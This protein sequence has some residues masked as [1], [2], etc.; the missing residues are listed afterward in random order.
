[1]G[2]FIL[3]GDGPLLHDGREY[4]PGETVEMAPEAAARFRP[5]RLEEG[6]DP[7]G[8]N[9]HSDPEPEPAPEPESEPEPEPEPKV[10]KKA[11]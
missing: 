7:A 3:K 5:G 1:M 6:S 2:R 4:H 8:A 10:K 11:K 9:L